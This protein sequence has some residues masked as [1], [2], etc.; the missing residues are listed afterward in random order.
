MKYLPLIFFLTASPLFGQVVRGV[1]LELG[2]DPADTGAIRLANAALIGWEASPAGTDVTFGVTAAERF[3]MSAGLDVTGTVSSTGLLLNSGAVVN[4]D[5]GDVTVTHS[6]NALTVAGGNLIALGGLASGSAILTSIETE[7]LNILDSVNQD[8]ALQIIVGSD[9]SVDRTLTLLTGDASRQMTLNGNPTLDDWFDQSVKAGASPTFVTVNAT[10]LNGDGGGIT[11][12]ASAHNGNLAVT[13][14]TLA[15]VAAAVDNLVLGGA[16]DFDALAEATEA[17]LDVDDVFAVS[18]DGTEKKITLEN[19]IDLFEVQNWTPTGTWDLSDAT[20]ILPSLGPVFITEQAAADADVAGKGQIWVANATPNTLQ[21]TD[22]A[23]TDHAIYNSGGT[24]VAVA[25]GGT[26]LSSGTSG[27]VL[28]FTAAGTLASSGAL[29]ANTIVIGGGPGAAPSTTATG[30]GVLTALGINTGSAGAFQV[31]NASGAALT[32]LTNLATTAGVAALSSGQINVNTTDKQIGVH[33]GTKEVAIPL[34]RK[35]PFSFDPKAVCDG[36][37]DRL[38]LFTVTEPKG[39]T[40][41]RWSASFEAD[42]TTEVDLDLKR[43]DAFIGVA[44]S[45]VMD[46]LDTTAGVSSETTAA[47]INGGAVVATNKVVYLEFG[48]A[49]TESTHQVIFEIEYEIEED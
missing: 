47:N 30:A 48:T 38:F 39:I 4:F 36:A 22:D 49:Y 37:V 5:G 27:G 32:G 42:P 1:R 43:A 28:A 26:G 15:E 46:V 33:N 2:N 19:A 12:D 40:I 24:D 20:V 34:T 11:Y 41:T 8:A 18:H 35:F 17:D 31:N 14:N 13:D 10:T 44:N 29:A 23:G 45:A 3:A 21:F 7:T 9:L 16:S 25:D 6:A